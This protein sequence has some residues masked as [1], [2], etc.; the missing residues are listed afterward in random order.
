MLRIK[1]KKNLS[2][3]AVVLYLTYKARHIL[4]Y[5]LQKSQRLTLSFV[6]KCNF[7]TSVNNYIAL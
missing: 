1:D 4:T 7:I 5:M 6:S 3:P 2:L